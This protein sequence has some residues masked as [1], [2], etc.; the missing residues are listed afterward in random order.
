MSV[1]NVGNKHAH[2][3]TLLHFYEENKF[4]IMR[5]KDVIPKGMEIADNYDLKKWDSTQVISVK[6]DNG[7]CYPARILQFGGM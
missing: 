6:W 1:G 3:F 7:F 5:L 4:S 2:I